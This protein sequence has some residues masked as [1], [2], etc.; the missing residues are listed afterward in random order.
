[1]I[2]GT[3]AAEGYVTIY[4]EVRLA[5]VVVVVVVDLVVLVVVVDQDNKSPLFLMLLQLMRI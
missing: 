4:A 1:V 5:V 2:T 3:D